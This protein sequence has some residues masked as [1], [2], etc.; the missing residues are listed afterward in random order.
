MS[1]KPISDFEKI[2]DRLDVVLELLDALQALP[3]DVKEAKAIVASVQQSN[4]L[5][6]A[7][8]KEQ[9]W[10]IKDQQKRLKKLETA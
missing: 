3:N 6:Y 8:L 5:C 2:R 7:V 9:G 4:E 1:P 10:L